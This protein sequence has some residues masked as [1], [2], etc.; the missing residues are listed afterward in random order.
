MKK[1]N[2]AHLIKPSLFYLEYHPF[3]P[4]IFT[5]LS[6]NAEYRMSSVLAG[7][8]FLWLLSRNYR[9]SRPTISP[10]VNLLSN[11]KWFF[12]N[13]VLKL[14][15]HFYKDCFQNT[16]TQAEHNVWNTRAERYKDFKWINENLCGVAVKMPSLR[17]WRSKFPLSYGSFLDDL[18][19][20]PP[21]FRW[22]H[23]QN[24]C[25]CGDKWKIHK[26]SCLELQEGKTACKS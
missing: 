1:K 23:S 4:Y 19:G 6:E 17:R 25:C 13:Y 11:L 24:Y 18:E 16:S 2:G 21:S 15:A 3:S 5:W 26:E 20:H 8:F 10:T 22:N 12:I 14:V 7:L 9:S